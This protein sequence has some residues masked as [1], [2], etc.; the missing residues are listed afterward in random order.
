M[1][2]N[3]PNLREI[4]STSAVGSLDVSCGSSHFFA[5]RSMARGRADGSRRKLFQ[6]GDAGRH[7]DEKVDDQEGEASR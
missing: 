4:R 7:A 3:Q 1:K 5:K 2:R 6:G